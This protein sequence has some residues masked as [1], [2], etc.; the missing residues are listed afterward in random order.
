MLNLGEPQYINND[1][2]KWWLDANLTEYCQRTDHNSVKLP[3][4]R[5]WIVQ[6]P[7]G[8]MTRLLTKASNIVHETP[9]LEAM[10]V[11]IDM[12]KVKANFDK[13]PNT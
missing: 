5:V 12:L 6:H 10:A 8:E 7:D 1:G 9:S 4:H 13:K 3:R 2:I 11:H